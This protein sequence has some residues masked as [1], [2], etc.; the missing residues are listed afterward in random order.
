MITDDQFIKAHNHAFDLTPN[1]SF[2]QRMAAVI[3]D[4]NGNILSEGVNEYQPHW[5]MCQDNG[6]RKDQIGAHCE[7]AAVRNYCLKHKIKDECSKKFFQICKQQDFNTM[8]VVRRKG[9]ISS[10]MR[11]SSKP[12]PS[13]QKFLK[14]CGFKFMVY[15]DENTNHYVKEKVK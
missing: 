1:A 12:C 11:G 8:V 14:K 3:L 7:L 2:R 13:C 4:S 15:F 10:L 9:G 6:Y 5:F